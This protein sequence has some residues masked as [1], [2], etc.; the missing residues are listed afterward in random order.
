MSNSPELVSLDCSQ[1]VWSRFFTVAPL[2]VI[3]TTDPGGAPDFA[4]KH[5]ATPMGWD[6]FFGFVCTPRHGTYRNIA[7]SGVFTVTFPNPS[8]V[9]L[10]SLAASP[11]CGEDDAKPV[12]ATFETIPAET[13]EGQFIADGQVFLEC[14]KYRIIDNFGENSLITGQIR[15]AR[16]HKDSLRVSERDD[17]DLLHSAPLLAYLDPWRYATIG[18]S[19]QFPAPQGMKK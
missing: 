15:S 9:I 16:V 13:V 19:N 6:N 11:R 14:E 3:G 5:M 2:V 12:L 7:R 10:A 8:Q 18:E 4:P 1:P 17:Q